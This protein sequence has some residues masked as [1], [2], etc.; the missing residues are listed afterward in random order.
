MTRIAAAACAALLCL[1][2]S[3]AVR[4]QARATPDLSAAAIEA[5]KLAQLHSLLVSW[6]GDLVLEHYAPKITA[7]RL[8]NIK[9]AS[10]SV[11]AALVGI[12]RDRK[13]LPTLD[14][15]IV[16]WFPGRCASPT[17]IPA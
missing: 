17:P 8:A 13:R 5:G 11:V 3:P 16:R 12:A 14:T 4:T 10:K 6:R 9:S 7:G 2:S 15:P 1:T